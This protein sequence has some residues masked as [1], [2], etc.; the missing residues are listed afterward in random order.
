MSL[1]KR[2]S[3][4]K[5]RAR[6]EQEREQTR[7]GE[8]KSP[9]LSP[10]V[11]KSQAA[12]AALGE[13]QESLV[14]QY[15][16]KPTKPTP[17]PV[18]LNRAEPEL[19]PEPVRV[20]EP[21][22]GIAFN[23]Y[24]LSFFCEEKIYNILF[25]PQEVKAKKLRDLELDFIHNKLKIYAEYSKEVNLGAFNDTLYYYRGEILIPEEFIN[26]SG[27]MRKFLNIEHVHVLYETGEILLQ[28]TEYCNFWL[29]R[30]PAF[31]EPVNIPLDKPKIQDEEVCLDCN[32]SCIFRYRQQM[33]N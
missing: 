21:T 30:A 29:K 2:W 9:V 19:V 6:K 1:L 27:F 15:A 13:K 3:P 16:Y 17:E 24:D 28:D 4:R 20:S 26:I 11:K 31:F 18:Q 8:T 7:T 5:T 23:L 22:T 14:E 32:L 25:L 33:I 12:R 10:V